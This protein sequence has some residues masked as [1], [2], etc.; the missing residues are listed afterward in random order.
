M[1]SL[2]LLL[3]RCVVAVARLARRPATA[4]TTVLYYGEALPRD[5][6]LERLVSYELLDGAD[7]L[8]LRF[9]VAIVKCVW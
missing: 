4:V 5:R 8:V 7:G 1:Q 9:L 3:V 2:M 6:G